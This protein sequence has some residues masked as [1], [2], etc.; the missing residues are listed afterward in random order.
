MTTICASLLAYHMMKR[1]DNTN[2]R[3]YLDEFVKTGSHPS[4]EV[5]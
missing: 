5:K 4:T 2:I 3:N 1:R